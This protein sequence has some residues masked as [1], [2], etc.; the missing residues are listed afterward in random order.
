MEIYAGRLVVHNT[1]GTDEKG[2]LSQQLRYRSSRCH[3]LETPTSRKAK[4]NAAASSCA[5]GVVESIIILERGREEEEEYD[6]IMMM[7]ML[8]RLCFCSV[9]GVR[10]PTHSTPGPVV[11]LHEKLPN[12]IPTFPYNNPL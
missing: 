7:M 1:L 12:V 4:S 11:Y 10:G 2:W 8:C 6:M 3:H 5:W 9:A